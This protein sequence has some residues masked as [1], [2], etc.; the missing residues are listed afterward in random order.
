[1]ATD[2]GSILY[3]SSA[4]ITD[5]TEFLRPAWQ[6]T[7]V[8][9]EYNGMP[10]QAQHEGEFIFAGEN[11][12][13]AY[14]YAL[15][16][17]HPTEVE[18]LRSGR[19]RPYNFMTNV[20]T[21]NVA[22]DGGDTLPHHTNIVLTV[23]TRPLGFLKTL[24]LAKPKIFAIN[25]KSR[26]RSYAFERVYHK[27]GSATSE[28]VCRTPIPIRECQVIPIDGI[29]QVMQEEV[30]VLFVNESV[31]KEQWF[32]KYFEARKNWSSRRDH[33]AFIDRMIKQGI[34][35][36][37]NRECGIHRLDFS[38]GRMMTPEQA[39]V[40]PGITSWQHEAIKE[41]ISKMQERE[42]EIS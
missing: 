17:N 20:S 33:L 29:D 37:A 31:S 22:D 7:A 1:M 39:S 2:Q 8:H 10:E 11:Q 40:S 15:S 27:D 19:T 24:Q 26:D 25:P 41:A 16:L 21:F 35:I 42:P 38:E 13:T 5:E 28:F 32:E 6:K 30:Q 36:H 3:H 12:A 34:L 4:N 23:I 14:A 9:N 18:I